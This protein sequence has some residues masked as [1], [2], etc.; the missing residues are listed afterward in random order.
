ML[1]TSSGRKKHLDSRG[2]STF[3]TIFLVLSIIFI[4]TIIIKRNQIID[5]WRLRGYKPP[6][7]VVS[8][9]SQDTMN[10][11]TKHLFYLNKPQILNTVSSFRVHCPEN[12]NTIVLGC[13][14]YNQNGIF[15][16]NVQDASLA[17]V[18]QVTAAHEV[19]HAIYARLSYFDRKKLNTELQ[20]YYD[21]GLTDPRVKAEVK[22]YQQTEPTA[23]YDEMSCTFGTEIASLPAN[24]TDYYNKFFDNRMTI[25]KYE[26][27]YVKEFTSRQSKISS[28]DAQLSSMNDQINA[29]MAKINSEQSDITNQY[30]KLN[31]L[32]T[33]NVSSYNQQIP[34]YNQ[35]VSTYNQEVTTTQALIDQ[36]NQ[37]VTTRNQI[38]VQLDTLSKAL[39]TRTTK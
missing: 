37:I 13:Y 19:L 10:S 11:Y 33:T 22:I 39:D 15:L 27:N 7:S 8:L 26:Q 1:K 5:W 14:H 29:N 31:T 25:V 30:A 23:I 32:K 38:A 20:D 2:L 4:A 9:A 36:Y 24:L 6:A 17:G 12:E 16:Y 21:H 3:E 28:F 35:L 34:A 18:Q